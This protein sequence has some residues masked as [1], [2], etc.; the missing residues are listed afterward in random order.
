MICSPYVSHCYLLVFVFEAKF[1]DISYIHPAF[2]SVLDFS[3]LLRLEKLVCSLRNAL[4]GFGFKVD[5]V[6]FL[7]FKI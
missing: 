7:P 4:K 1:S 2:T 3:I 5:C 6:S